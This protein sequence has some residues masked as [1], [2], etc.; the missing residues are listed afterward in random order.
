MSATEDAGWSSLAELRERLIRL[1]KERFRHEPFQISIVAHDDRFELHGTVSS[2]EMRST[3]MRLL[4]SFAGIP[5]IVNLL[6]VAAPFEPASDTDWFGDH[7]FGAINTPSVAKRDRFGRE[8]VPS[9]ERREPVTKGPSGTDPP[10]RPSDHELKLEV[11]PADLG[12][13]DLTNAPQIAGSKPIE[14]YPSIEADRA[15][16]LGEQ[17]L[18]KVDLATTPSTLQSTTLLLATLADGWGSLDIDV[19]ITGPALRDIRPSRGVV[20]VNEDGTSIP[21]TFDVAL[22]ESVLEDA[23]VVVHAV[24]S[25]NGG[26]SGYLEAS[27]GRVQPGAGEKSGAKQVVP[28]SIRREYIPPTMTVSI[29]PS[30]A[31]LTWIWNTYPPMGASAGSSSGLTTIGS[32]AAG[33]ARGLLQACPGMPSDAFRKRMRG[34]GEK[35]WSAAPREFRDTYVALRDLHGPGFPIQFM[36]GEFNVPWEMMRPDADIVPDADHLFL[37]HPTARWPLT[38]GNSLLSRLP[39]GRVHSFVPEYAANGTLPAARAEGAWLVANLAAEAATAS[40]QGLFDVLES[41]G[42][43]PTVSLVHFAGHGCAS[44]GEFDASIEMEDGLVYLDEVDTSGT[45]LGKRDRS[46]LVLNACEAAATVVQLGFVE[47]WAPRLAARG[48]GAVVAPLWRVQDKV[49]RDVMIS[50]LDSLILKGNTLGEAFT[51]AR[52]Q[53]S[54]RSIASFAYLAYGDVMATMAASHATVTSAST[55]TRASASE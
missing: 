42:S 23:E 35:I 31:E 40:K 16:Q 32:E 45:V 34:I 51:T 7:D 25:Y 19:A 2:E 9:G 29:I 50:G 21:A 46:M 5:L 49:A 43:T 37:I 36:T 33:F 22:S 48:F 13:I 44:T 20:T 10:K 41:G 27:V 24:F 54:E 39:V 1:I 4:A 6:E 17:F 47:G 26:A 3:A 55:G 12:Q 28:I 15:P 30:G 8:S 53:A 52:R 38:C 14:R 11:D 18:V